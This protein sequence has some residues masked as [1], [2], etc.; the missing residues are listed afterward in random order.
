MN[1]RKGR[2][3]VHLQLQK[4]RYLRLFVSHQ[5]S[6]SNQ[7]CTAS[8]FANPFAPVKPPTT[9]AKWA[10]PTAKT[11]ARIDV[12]GYAFSPSASVDRA[13]ISALRSV[14]LC[15]GGDGVGL[16]LPNGGVWGDV[17]DGWEGAWRTLNR[18]SF[19][20][21]TRT[22]S[23]AIA[24]SD[25][26]SVPHS[27]NRETHSRFLA[28]SFPPAAFIPSRNHSLILRISPIDAFVFT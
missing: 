2:L 15:G 21:K 18:P 22:A 9:S 24:P 8:N 6:P 12:S 25:E 16:G 28:T 13:I 19:S 10:M 3:A 23:S 5:N 27:S 17:E 4:F 1:E 11:T 26:A 14:C 7:A 20:S